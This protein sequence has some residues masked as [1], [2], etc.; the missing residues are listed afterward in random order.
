MIRELV[1]AARRGLTRNVAFTTAHSPDH[2]LRGRTYIVP[3]DAVW[4]ASLGLVDG[5]IRRW[6]LQESDDHE[7]IIRGTAHG[8]VDRFTSAVT[9]RIT[10]DIDAQ[11]RVDGLSAF[12]VGRADL[13]MNARR[14]N[15][16]F[17]QLD[18]ELAAARGVDPG[19]LCVEPADPESAPAS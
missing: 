15:R 9:I 5:G 17:R 6:E 3:F 4:Q 10:L 8:L 19:A 18:R 11:T 2:R 7:G 14:L 16:F 1:Q 12:R 13:G